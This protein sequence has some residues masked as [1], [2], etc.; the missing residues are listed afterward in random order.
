MHGSFF[1][2]DR[3]GSRCGF[4]KLSPARSCSKHSAMCFFFS[5][6]D[7]LG[8]SQ[9]KAS[10]ACHFRQPPLTAVNSRTLTVAFDTFTLTCDRSGVTQSTFMPKKTSCHNSRCH[11]YENRIKLHVGR[12]EN[13]LQ[14]LFVSANSA[15]DAAFLTRNLHHLAFVVFAYNLFFFFFFASCTVA[16]SR[17]E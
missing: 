12:Q 4:T 11:Q 13:V 10:C 15:V 8:D 7:A 2:P 5:S 3:C 14:V 16:L 1:V 6:F 17:N 9:F